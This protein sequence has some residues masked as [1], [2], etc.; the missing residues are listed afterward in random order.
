MTIQI[1]PIA[2]PPR[3]WRN[4]NQATHTDRVNARHQAVTAIQVGGGVWRS[5]AMGR[6]TKEAGDGGD[7][8]RSIRA[9]EDC[10]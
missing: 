8:H 1:T 10:C 7:P 4:H 6:S 2:L 5:A 3:T 9:D